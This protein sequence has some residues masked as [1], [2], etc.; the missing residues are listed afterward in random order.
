MNNPTQQNYHL[1]V[2][3]HNTGRLAEAERLL[4]ELTAQSPYLADGMNQ[5]AIVLC[6]LGKFSESRAFMNRAIACNPSNPEYKNNMGMILATMGKHGEAIASYRDAISSHPEYAEAHMNLGNAQ[7]ALGRL[8]EA[9]ASYRWALTLRP[10]FPHALSNLAQAL[11]EQGKI[12]EAIELCQKAMRLMPNFPQA[13]QNLANALLKDQQWDEAIAACQRALALQ[14]NFPEA[15]NTLGNALMAKDLIEPALGAF[16]R[17]ISMRPTY[18]EAFVNLGNALRKSN[19]PAEAEVMLRYAIAQKPDVPEAYSTLGVV[20]FGQDRYAEAIAAFRKALSLRPADF[21]SIAPLLASALSRNGNYD[22]CIAVC[23][24]AIE[25]VPESP[26]AHFHLG[27]TLLRLG[28][29]K[30][31]WKEYEWRIPAKVLPLRRYDYPQPRW[32]GEELGGKTILIYTEQG[33]G[34][35]IQFARYLPL[36]ARRGGKII[37]Q[38]ESGH[39]GPLER[40]LQAVEGVQSVV[41]IDTPDVQFDVYCSIVSLPSILDIEIPS[42]PFISADA[43]LVEQFRNLMPNDQRI[44]IGLVWAGASKNPEDDIRSTSL[45]AMAPLAQSGDFWF[46][47]LQKGDAAAEAKNPPKGMNLVDFSDRI[48]DFADTAA[49]IANLDLVISVDTAVAHL[50]GA[51]GKPVWL[52]I[53]VAS[54]W[55][56]MLNRDDS[57]WYPSMRIFR[58]NKLKDWQTPIGR[59][60]ESLRQ[61]HRV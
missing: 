25:R 13:Q 51:M 54:D 3:Y 34:D 26:L 20:L 28:D 37:V 33:F 6:K 15:Y 31:G 46:C 10:D 48:N 14:P 42:E 40:L 12:A 19:R 44:K 4:R 29:F 49:I 7:M 61:F 52:L 58:Q 50:A 56:W 55:R 38:C 24:Q 5:L 43:E 35:T 32:T 27:M 53:Q 21:D 1:A 16:G 41:S 22:E 2:E 36:V 8:D 23:K 45:S 18:N 47:S 60:S 30:N 59:L 39:F 17:A 9:V 11:T 57:P